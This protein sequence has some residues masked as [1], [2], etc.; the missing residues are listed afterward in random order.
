MSVILMGSQVFLD[1]LL[2]S[3]LEGPLSGAAKA[4]AVLNVY[5]AKVSCLTDYLMSTQKG[6]S[7]QA[8][9]HD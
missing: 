6:N 8:Y 4:A 7:H 9:A 5:Q 2:C 3:V 1:C